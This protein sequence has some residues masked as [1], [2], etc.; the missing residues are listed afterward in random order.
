[1]ERAHLGQD[2]DLYGTFLNTAMDIPIPQKAGNPLG[3]A[4]I[5]NTGSTLRS[6]FVQIIKLSD[7]T[8]FNF[9]LREIRVYSK[10][11]NV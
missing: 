4:K 9:R 2:S 7:I 1:V 10:S 11:K 3:S 6:K 5:L 8:R